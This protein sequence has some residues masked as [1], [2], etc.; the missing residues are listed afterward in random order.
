MQPLS[1]T[2]VACFTT[3]SMFQILSRVCVCIMCVLCRC[4]VYLSVKGKTIDVLAEA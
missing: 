4:W 2:H 3:H 1:L